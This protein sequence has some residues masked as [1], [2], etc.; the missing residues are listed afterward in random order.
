M[1]TK[2]EIIMYRLNGKKICRL[3]GNFI[4]VD[5]D[6]QLMACQPNGITP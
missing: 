4:L 6:G 2:R 5:G 3:G 1:S